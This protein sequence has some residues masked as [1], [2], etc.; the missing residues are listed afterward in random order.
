[1]TAG[2][3]VRAFAPASVSNVGCSFD[4]FGFAVAGLGDV[5]EAR[6]RPE[7]GVVVAEITGDGGRLLHDPE[8]NTAAVAAARLLRDAGKEATAGV[9]L[10]LA[11]GMPLG[12]GLGSSAAS[13]VAL[14]VVVSA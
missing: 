13:A 5:V 2:P 9:E 10:R 7:P 12:S 8:R 6:R 14:A 4:V 11:K 3:A 1:M